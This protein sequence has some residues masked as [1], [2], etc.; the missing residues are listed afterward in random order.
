MTQRSVRVNELLMREIS[1]IIHVMFRTEM[2]CVS[3]TGVDVSPDLRN[4]TVFFSVIGDNRYVEEK[5]KFINKR[6][7]V[8]RSELAKRIILKYLPDLNF[9]YDD[10]IERGARVIQILEELEDTDPNASSP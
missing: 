5:T 6:K 2:V 7:G 9:V 10:A 4:A 1:D 8:I 3:I